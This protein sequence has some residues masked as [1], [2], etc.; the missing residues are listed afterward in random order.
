MN[1]EEKSH[2][3]VELKSRDE[4]NSTRR[5][6]NTVAATDPDAINAFNVIF[7]CRKV[8]Q[9]ISFENEKKKVMIFPYKDELCLQQTVKLLILNAINTELGQVLL[10]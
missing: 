9:F 7:D 4:G 8:D 5:V 10:S 2:F 3:A 6:V 1:F